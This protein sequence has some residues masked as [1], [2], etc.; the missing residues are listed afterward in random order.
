MT[1]FE[2]KNGVLISCTTDEAEITVPEGVTEI[3]DYAFCDNRRVTKITLPDSVERLGEDVF[4]HCYSLKEISLPDSIK[5]IGEFTFKSCRS[6]VKVKLPKDFKVVMPNMFDGCT[7]LTD[8]SFLDGMEAISNK[9]FRG[10]TSLK[11]VRIPDSIKQVGGSV[12]MNCTGLTDVYIPDSVTGFDSGVFDGCTSLR[13]ARLSENTKELVCDVFRGC[14]S[15]KEVRVPKSCKWIGRDVFDKSGTERVIV[16]EN[17]QE[18]LTLALGDK[19]KELVIEGSKGT[20]VLYERLPYFQNDRSRSFF[21]AV[22]NKKYLGSFFKNKDYMAK[23]KI[24]VALYH[25]GERLA[26]KYIKKELEQVIG[27]CVLHNDTDNL[28]RLA[29]NKFIKQNRLDELLE[30]AELINNN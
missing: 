5:E 14:T 28:R 17:M 8:L 9:A 3:G 1:N 23:E 18:F 16:S 15:L 2:I 7:S 6:L 29:E 22:R 27:Y 11:E 24:P 20:I 30:Q 19:I 13:N 25:I 4:S 10:C 12:F 21:E 26:D